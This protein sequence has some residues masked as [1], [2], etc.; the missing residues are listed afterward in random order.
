M[1]EIAIWSNI[2][3][4]DNEF[5]FQH[6][7]ETVRSLLSGVT[8]AATSRLDLMLLKLILASCLSPQVTKISFNLRKK[9]LV[10]SI[11]NRFL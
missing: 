3:I 11:L 9:Y 1:T 6:D 10:G 2:D 5:R 7:P 4:R 8:S